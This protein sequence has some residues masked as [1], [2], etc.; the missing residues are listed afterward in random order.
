[1]SEVSSA[2]LSPLGFLIRSASVW[3]R[4]PAVVDGDRVWTYAEHHDRVQALAGLLTSRFGVA[5][6]D[7]VATLLPN[8]ATM[9]E[10]HYAVPGVGAVL[11]PL[12]TRLTAGDYAYILDH[13]GAALVIAERAQADVLAGIELP[14]LW[15]DELDDLLAAAPRLAL[16]LPA[17]ENT[18]LSINY[19][20]GTT[21]RPKG[22]MTSHRGAYL[23]TLGVVTEAGLRTTSAYLWTLPMFHCN[24]WAYTW[25]VTAAGAS[26]VCLPKVTGEAMWAAIDDHGVT[27]LCAAPTVLAT[28]LTDAAA[29]PLTTP[30]RIFVGGA[31]PAPALIE[32]AERLGIAVT[33]LY[34]LTE[35]YGPIAV[36]A[37]N[38]DWDALDEGE[39][40]RL[41]AR[42]GVPTI[43]SERLRVVDE[44]LRD[45]PADAATMGEVVMR[46]N[47]VMLGYYRDPEATAEAFR[48]GWFHSGDL[49]V[50]HPDGYIELRD[51]AK[52]V[53]ISGGENISTIEVEQALVAH[54]DV[55]EAAVVAA[56]DERW[57]EVPVAYVIAKPNHADEAELLEFVRG[58]IARFK[59][60]KHIAFVDELPKTA[61]GKIQKFLL[62]GTATAEL[63][64]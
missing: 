50:M 63:K 59:A 29:H 53:I 49:A 10:A 11:V 4:R 6:G 39:Q 12:N 18:L 27:D 51:R 43:V 35:T 20:S 23:H 15:T 17:D 2:P 40:S 37:W 33:H 8:I 38:P 19:T 24:G 52:D 60:P 21:G 9:L 57:G 47:N 1:M 54:P 55:L 41:R 56:P 5:P 45:V 16:T 58:R 22:V 3:A 62:R 32:R 34:G 28:L 26:H 30:V 48:G 14:V 13:S 44:Q 42:Q 25:A 31:P 61:T 36:C 46:G 64:H 7:R